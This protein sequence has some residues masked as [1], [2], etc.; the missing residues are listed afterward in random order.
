MLS[1]IVLQGR[2]C[3]QLP[4]GQRERSRHLIVSGFGKTGV[5]G[6]LHIS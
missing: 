5:A 1:C 3:V 2:R 6:C 4:T